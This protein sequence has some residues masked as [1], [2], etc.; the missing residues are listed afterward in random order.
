MRASPNA[1]EEGAIA[2]S[3]ARG[4][5]INA[6]LGSCQSSVCRSSSIV[7]LALRRVGGVH[8]TLRAAGEVPQEPAVDRAEG[9]LPGLRARSRTRHVVEDPRDLRAREVRGQR[10]PHVRAQAVQAR[11][12]RELAH[13][14]VGARVLPHDRVAQRRAAPAIPH[15]GGL[16]LVGDAERG[17]VG[18]ARAGGRERGLRP[19]RTRVPISPRRRARPTPRADGSGGARAGRARRCA[20]R[21]RTGS[22]ACSSSPGLSPP[23]TSPRVASLRAARRGRSR[24]QC[25]PRS[26]RAEVWCAAVSPLLLT[27]LRSLARWLVRAGTCA[28]SARGSLRLTTAVA[29]VIALA[30]G[31]TMP[32]AGNA[33]RSRARAA[34]SEQHRAA[35]A[36][37][38]GSGPGN[39]PTSGNTPGSAV[40]SGKAP[41]RNAPAPPGSYRIVGCRSSGEAAYR[42]GPAR[43]EVAIGFDDGPGPD[44]P[45]FVTMLER[46]HARATF[47]MIGEQVTSAYRTTLLRELRNGDVLG[48]HTFTHPYLTQSANVFGQL[49]STISAIRGLT[50]YTPCVFR[51][52][53]GAYDAS[54]IR[55]ARSLGLATVLW[56]VDPADYT[57][58]GAGAIVSRVLAQV[59]PGSIIISHD[60]GGPRGQTLAAYPAIISALRKRGYRDRDD[61]RTARLQAD[62]RAMHQAVRRDRGQALGAPARR[63]REARGRA[64]AA[65]SSKRG[66]GHLRAARPRACAGRSAQVAAS[67]CGASLQDSPRRAGLRTIRRSGPTRPEQ[68]Q[69]SAPVAQWS[70]VLFGE[71]KSSGLSSRR[72]R[73]RF[74]PGAL[75]KRGG[76]AATTALRTSGCDTAISARHGC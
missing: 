65:G 3:S 23:R 55:T 68:S 42:H 64:V 17:H 47:F 58:P 6:R 62:L 41:G 37:A 21:R 34:R 59:Q 25:C 30:L 7:R 31:V 48:D 45:A 52:P 8:A 36:H 5:P 51:P 18:G 70:T 16:A 28:P 38:A 9:E 26:P 11:V 57:L 43:R 72:P 20:R 4:M 24:V 49:Q 71:P 54:V 69:Y 50:G 61:P 27:R 53:Y 14:R 73:V 39:P 19:P 44:T 60:G 75:R 15:D 74:P 13:E 67:S 63:D 32:A 46:A 1:C 76:F 12:A 66:P 10:Q 2:G 29:P 35:G 33:G 40:G 22:P 56:N